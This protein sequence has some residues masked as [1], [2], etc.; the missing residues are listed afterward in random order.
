MTGAPLEVEGYRLDGDRAYH[1]DTHVWVDQLGDGGVRIG[2]DPLGVETTGTLAQ[3]S[4]IEPGAIV[5]AGEPLGSVEAEKF[6]GPLA[7]PVSGTVT[8]VNHDAVADPHL[9]HRDPLGTWLV[10]LAPTELEAELSTLVR[11]EAIAE[12]FVRRLATYRLEGVLAE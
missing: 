9:L 4:L 1:P 3:L 12:W 6:V 7:S 5:A 11:G 10:E 8:A 2:L